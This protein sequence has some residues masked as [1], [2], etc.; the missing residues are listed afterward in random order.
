MPRRRHHLT[1]LLVAAAL[2]GCG[3]GPGTPTPAPTLTASSSPAATS[4]PTPTPEPEPLTEAKAARA[5]AEVA[6]PAAYRLDL[7]C[8]PKTAQD[9]RICRAP[10][11]D[12][13]AWSA[14]RTYLGPVLPGTSGFPATVTMNLVEAKT[15]AAADALYEQKVRG[16]RARDGSYDIPIKQKSGS[17]TPGERGRGSLQ[18]TTSGS[19]RGTEL[20]DRF[21]MVYD[22]SS[23][24]SKKLT[25][26]TR[27]Q[28]RGVYVSDV[29]WTA[30]K[31]SAI[32]DLADL[33]DRVSTAL[34]QS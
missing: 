29:S 24:T 18:P 8:P 17:Y 31:A 16:L 10:L 2:T 28:R 26:R 9:K 11:D 19:W 25:S 33:P 32:S 15:E 14:S 34:D 27:V 30:T 1:A 5:F 13:L 12:D 7:Q 22:G 3:G 23:S 21:V 6:V 4:T 20:R